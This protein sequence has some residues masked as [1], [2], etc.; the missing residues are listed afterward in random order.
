MYLHSLDTQLDEHGKHCGLKCH[1]D[2]TPHLVKTWR[3]NT[4]VYCTAVPRKPASTSQRALVLGV[5]ASSGLMRRDD[6]IK[7]AALC[8]IPPYTVHPL[9]AVSANLPL[10][11]TAHSESWANSLNI[12]LQCQS[13]APTLAAESQRKC[14]RWL[15]V[16]SFRS[17]RASIRQ[18]VT[19]NSLLTGHGQQSRNHGTDSELNC[20]SPRGRLTSVSQPHDGI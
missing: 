13:C 11:P 9:P 12:G 19:T 20:E 7:H 15:L 14:C 6:L 4:L 1:E 5:R 2:G 17:D 8:P 10:Q 16:S 3:H 18:T